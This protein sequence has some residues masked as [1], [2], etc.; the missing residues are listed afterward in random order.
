MVSQDPGDIRLPQER[1]MAKWAVE[2]WADFPVDR[3]PRP[4]ISTGPIV[5]PEKGFRTGNAKIAFIRGDIEVQG[6]VPNDVLVIL[7][8][9]GS[10]ERHPGPEVAPLVLSDGTKAETTF[11][12]D[13]GQRMLSAWRFHGEELLGLLWVLDPEI[14]ASQ[15]RPLETPDQP[16]PAGRHVHRS[17]RSRIETDDHTLHFE[18]TGGSPDWVDYPA[19]E[20]V[21]S[22]QAVAVIPVEL[23]HGPPGPRRAIGYRREAVFQLRSP[24]GDR[25]L[26][27]L[28]ASPVSVVP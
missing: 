20:V 16:A 13:R 6:S 14:A 10:S 2:R 27:N 28:D 17:F 7:R 26:V 4:L 22:D 1:A 15:W 25:V 5:N 11:S 12:T 9:R 8:D 19:S 24:F 23:D 21:E 3:H 18:F